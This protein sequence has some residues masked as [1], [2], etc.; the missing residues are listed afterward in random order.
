MA[1]S[2]ACLHINDTRAVGPLL[3][4]LKEARKKK[5][6]SVIN[7]AENALGDLTKIYGPDKDKQWEDWWSKKK[8]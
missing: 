5:D 8:T 4:V 6:I 3:E 7:N 2:D 1:A